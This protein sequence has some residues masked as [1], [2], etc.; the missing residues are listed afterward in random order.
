MNILF[1]FEGVLL[2][3][4]IYVTLYNAIFSLAGKLFYKHKLGNSN[5]LAAKSFAVFI[6]AYKEDGV[7]FEIAQ[8]AL[9]QDY[10]FSDYR[11]VV[12]ADTLLSDTL[13]KL[14]TLPIKL[15][16]VSFD[17]S[18]KVKA[19]NVALMEMQGQFDYA[20][21]LDAD[22]IMEP[23]FL[24]TLNAIHAQGYQAIQGR[25]AAKNKDTTM[26]F[27]DGLSEEINNH[28][29]CKG[30]TALKLS[31]S[32]KGSGM[33]FRYD[34][35]QNE[36]SVMDSIGGFDRE[37]ELRLVKK[38]HKVLYVESA[39]VYDEKVGN[40]EVF[41]NQRKRWISSQYHYLFQYFFSG[42]KG[43]FLAEMSY[44]NSTV[45]RNVQLPR[46]L[47]L[48]LLA[49]F[50]ITSIVLSFVFKT[51]FQIWI[52]LSAITALSILLAIPSEYFGKQLVKAISSLP[53]IFMRMFL[54]VFKLKGANKKF[55]HTPHSVSKVSDNKP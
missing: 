18:T 11:V 29:M 51:Q 44:F 17:R 55:I 37:L 6:P 30:S 50:T 28:V 24:K 41:E 12:I 53:V 26:S 27:L 43:L 31:S 36:L 54:L 7:I 34:L 25:R 5:T 52:A 46:L 13:D 39:V 1:W 10:N 49:L 42:I 8:N 48:G 35:L 38:G 21:I 20:V 23:G 2:A 19:L 40:Y 15:I 45:L 3:Y 16:E 33:S 9:K 22:N 32:L 14:R 4:F 47:N